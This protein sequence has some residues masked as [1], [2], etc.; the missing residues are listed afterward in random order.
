M[1]DVAVVGLGPAGRSLASRCAAAGLDVVA[2]DPRPAAIWT[3]TYGLWADELGSLPPSVVRHATA[4]PWIVAQDAHPLERSYVVLDNKAVHDHYD[5]SAATV[6]RERLDDGGVL[7]LRAQAR[8]VVDAR[9]ARPSGVL[10]GDPSPHQTAFG[11]VV[12]AEDAA[13]AL[14]GAPGLLMDWRTDWHRPPGRGSDAEAGTTRG[15]AVV[16]PDTVENGGTAFDRVPTFLY[17]IALGEDRVLLEETCLAAAPGLPIA[18]LKARL[19]TRLTR[20]GVPERA[21]A[22]PLEREIVSIPMLGRDRAPLPGTLAAGVAGRGG[23]VVTGYSVAHSFAVADRLS[24]ALAR[25]ETPDEVDPRR[26][27]DVARAA[28]LRALLGLDVTGTGALFEAFG[29][30]PPRSQAAYL[31]R[32]SALAPVLAAMWGMFARMPPRAQWALARATL[33]GHPRR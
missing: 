5:L 10:P 32:D 4:S 21:I 14:D 9:G 11:I 26:P 29:G 16:S 23:H 6:R 22:A 8:V 28:G 20:R 1:F 12:R 24:R 31:S 3:P 30:L 15:V 33:R 7:A 17:A 2:F 19:R 27:A 25:G 18:E 13:P